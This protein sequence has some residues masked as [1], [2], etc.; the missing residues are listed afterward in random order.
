MH[1]APRACALLAA[2]VLAVGA[3]PTLGYYQRPGMLLVALGS[4][5]AAVAVF[6]GAW[7]AR[8]CGHEPVRRGLAAAGP[9]LLLF[10]ACRAALEPRPS[11][12]VPSFAALAVLILAVALARRAEEPDPLRCAAPGLL[13]ACAGSALIHAR[14]LYAVRPVGL[15]AVWYGMWL[16]VALA[17]LALSGR[18]L[19]R[20]WW[21][22][23][24]LGGLFVAGLAV[25]GGALVASPDPVIDV[26]AV[27]D[28]TPKALLRGENPYRYPL[29]SPYGTERARR[30]GVGGRAADPDPPI[31]TPGYLFLFLP[32]AVA[33]VDPRW[34]L[35]LC[36]LALAGLVVWW[37][38]RE[39]APGTAVWLAG[40]L[41]LIPC[42]CA[43]AEQAWFDAGVGLFV[44]AGLLPLA[45]WL[46]GALAGFGVTVKQ[47]GLF[48]LPA[49]WA[50]WRAERPAWRTM[51]AMI[52]APN[53]IFVVWDAR[54]YAKDVL[55]GFLK[56]GIWSP[57]L[58]LPGL[59]E[60]EL[61]WHVPSA[62]SLAMLVSAVGLGVLAARL[63]GRSPAA[64]ARAMGFALVALNLL[65]RPAFVN[66][67]ELAAAVLL[68][69]AAWPEGE[70]DGE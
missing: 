10:T 31:Y 66:H 47:N 45:P 34:M 49:L 22:G 59:L 6:G 11:P 42:A 20:R 57:A 16:G 23:A 43:T 51:L 44:V 24:V 7:L 54:E 67:H 68:S 55:L 12:V 37:A 53:L 48:C 46:A 5:L 28:Q 52:L 14:L 17:M 56:P 58:C 4:A 3:V 19:G 41:L 32:A 29:V 60:A 62:L 40:V 64:Q 1:R 63:A 50:R 25:R 39:E 13:V 69:G 70:P 2:V 18:W 30:F 33:G 65:N 21:R 38:G 27:I 26:H 9:A 8:A 61:G 15:M 36:W 35:V